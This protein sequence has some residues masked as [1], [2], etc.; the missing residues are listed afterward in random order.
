MAEVFK[1]YVKYLLNNHMDK[2]VDDFVT[3][4]NDYKTSEI[5]DTRQAEAEIHLRYRSKIYDYLQGIYDNSFRETEYLLNKW[6]EYK[7]RSSKPGHVIRPENIIES[8]MLLH[9]ILK[10][11]LNFYTNDVQAHHLILQNLD[12]IEE[13]VEEMVI[14]EFQLMKKANIRR[15]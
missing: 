6:N 2:I 3:L 10:S 9:G 13:V 11:Y 14:R 7:L 4:L 5:W 12:T 8:Y 1:D 15:Y